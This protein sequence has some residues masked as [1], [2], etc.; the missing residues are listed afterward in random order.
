MSGVCVCERVCSVYVLC[1]VCVECVFTPSHTHTH[2]GLHR[3]VEMPV[4][5]GKF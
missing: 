2:H 4:E 5:K 3:F 1:C